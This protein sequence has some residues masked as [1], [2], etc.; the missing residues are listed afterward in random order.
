M[1][2]GALLAALLMAW[3]ALRR[4][5]RR[6]WVMAPV[7]ALMGADWAENLAQLRVISHWSAHGES[8]LPSG[9]IAVASAAT[10]VK[11]LLIGVCVA[12]LLA[13]LVWYAARAPALRPADGTVAAS[14]PD[15][16]A[17]AGS[18]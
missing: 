9:W 17:R 14:G 2:G 4:P 13:L 12:G 3:N 1:Y 7:L 8:A 6:A 16:A 10:V 18:G 15:G 11:C 5:F